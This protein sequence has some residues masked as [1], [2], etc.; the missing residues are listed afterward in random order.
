M[1]GLIEALALAVTLLGLGVG[2]LVVEDYMAA[3]KK[4]KDD[5]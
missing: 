3:R 5:Q 1:I 2:A 4:R